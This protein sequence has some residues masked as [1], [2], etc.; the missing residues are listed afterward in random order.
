LQRREARPYLPEAKREGKMGKGK[1][2]SIRQNTMNRAKLNAMESHGKREDTM[3]PARRVRDVEPLVYGSLN[4]AEARD[5]HMEGVQ[6]QGATEALHMFVQFPTDLPGAETPAKQKRMLEMAV[7]FAN[8]YHGGDAVF[9]AR[10]DRD[11]KGRHGVDV[12]LMPRYD[13]QYKDGRTVK[14]AAVSKFSKQHA[15]AR[16]ASLQE[17]GKPIDPE[18]P[19]MQ[20]RAM[21]Q[22]WFEHLQQA[23]VRWVEPPQR[24]ATRSKDRMEPE[25]YSLAQDRARLDTERVALASRLADVEAREE[26]ILKAARIIETARRMNGQ[27]VAPDLAS[28]ADRGRR[29]LGQDQTK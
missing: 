22:A 13:F 8:T 29:R 26:A 28:L 27:P 2:G 3:G 23:G 1:T 18:G 4:L 9:A 5:R 10:L 25:A 16:S 21:Q 6:Q 14:R 12:F 15:R 19:I 7:E 11:E 17:P 20:G 24:K